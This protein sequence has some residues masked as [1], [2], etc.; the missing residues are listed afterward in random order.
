MS[1]KIKP[2]VYTPELVDR[3]YSIPK[4]TLANLRSQGVGPKWYKKGRRVFYR[5]EDLEA[6]L[7]SEPHMTID[8]IKGRQ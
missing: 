1:N 8:S 6:W 7:F 5:R 3:D 4:G 2:E